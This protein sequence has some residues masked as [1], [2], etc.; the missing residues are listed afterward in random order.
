MIQSLYR[1]YRSRNIVKIYFNERKHKI[2]KIQK[3]V[4]GFLLRMRLKKDLR[5]M[6]V[7]TNEEH[8]MMSNVDLRRRAAAKRIYLQMMEFYNRRETLRKRISA[9]LKIQ[10]YWKMRYVKNTSFINAL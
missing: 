10:T 3:I 6:L 7:W 1:G 5:D 4:R 2:I 8:L 9:A